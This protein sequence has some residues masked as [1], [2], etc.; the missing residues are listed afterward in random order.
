MSMA[1]ADG[2]PLTP[3]QRGAAALE[4]AQTTMPEATNAKLLQAVL[5][6]E[7]AA[8]LTADSAFAARVHQRYAQLA[9]PAARPKTPRGAGSRTSRPT[10]KVSDFLEPLVPIKRIPNYEITLAGPLD[11]YLLLEVF[12]PHQI[13]RALGQ[14]SPA[15]VRKAVAI[16]RE[17]N[18][19]TQP[20]PKA[21]KAQLIAFIVE[22]VVGPI[23]A[24]VDVS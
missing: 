22:Q 11:P 12:G 10:P 17:R 2:V 4:H 7:A 8:A 23:P 3:A 15:D 18:P 6:E 20:P 21:T 9:A 5:L 16:L 24:G 13:E 14:R 1:T 19:D